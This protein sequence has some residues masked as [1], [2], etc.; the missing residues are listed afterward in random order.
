M[1]E[2]IFLLVLAGIWIFFA[3]V[4][5]LRIREVPDWLSFSLI[6][7][8]LSFRFFYCLFDAESFAFFY[9]G[10]I[11]LGIFFV[12]GNVLYYSHFFA[13]GDAK[14]MIALGTI[15]PL[16]ESFMVNLNIFA[17]FLILFLFAGAFYGLIYSFVLMFLNF[18]KFR[19]EFGRLAKKNKIF[20]YSIM[21]FGLGFMLVGFVIER[22]MFYLGV[23]IFILPYV[24][25]LAKV[26]EKVCMIK[27][28]NPK[29]LVEGDWLFKDVKIGNKIIKSK[30]DGLSK[31]E[32][33]LIRKSKKEILVKQGIP[34]V[35][36]FLI[37]FLVLVW[38]LRNSFWEFN[39]F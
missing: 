7:F 2:I 37:S 4:Q 15:L 30:W 21:F 27:K 18:G 19:I 10:L 24:F 1:Y 8:A 17:V 3:S 14:L 22:M 26:V 31:S 20:I 34:F 39:V 9:Q 12:I 11:G 23:L 5:D 38:L 16:S 36:V 29:D 28:V 32:I 33:A 25:L 6:I 35:P 13:G